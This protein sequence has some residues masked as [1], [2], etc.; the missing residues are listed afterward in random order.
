MNEMDES[1]SF[2]ERGKN[3]VAFRGDLFFTVK[4]KIIMMRLQLYLM[5]IVTVIGLQCICCDFFETFEAK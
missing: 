1:K 2:L 3:V 4:S 5:E